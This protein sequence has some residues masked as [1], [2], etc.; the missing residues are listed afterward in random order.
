MG[1][2]L[3]LFSGSAEAGEQLHVLT[4]GGID[5]LANL[6]VETPF[7]QPPQL[8]RGT[9]TE[10]SLTGGGLA[11]YT[12]VVVLPGGHLLL[13]DGAGRGAVRFDDDGEQVDQ[14]FSA[15]EISAPPSVVAA[16][17][18]TTNE[19]DLL[20]MAD[21]TTGHLR[22]YDRVADSYVWNHASIFDG[23][24]P[25]VA[26][27]IAM[28]DKRVAAAG[29]WADESLG[30]VEVLSRETGAEPELVVLSEP[31][32]ERPDA[33]II[34]GLFPV[35]DLM[36]D[37]DGRLLITSRTGVFVVDSGGELLWHFDIGDDADVGGELQSA[38]WLDSGLIAAATRQPGLWNEP[39][40]HHRVHL[41]DPGEEV[42]V[43][44]TSD[45][46][47]AAPLRLE[48]AAGHGATGTRDYSADA[49]DFDDA[50]PEA[51]NVDYGPIID[52]EQIPFDDSSSLSFAV[53]NETAKPVTVRRAEFRV[54]NDACDQLAVPDHLHR[55]WWGYYQTRTIESG[56]GWEMSNQFLDAGD[57]GAGFWC[58]QLMM[59]GRDGQA[60]EVGDPVDFTVLDPAGAD[61]PVT[62]E[63]L[64]EFDPVDAGQPDDAGTSS[65]AN[66]TGNDGE[67]CSCAASSPT[68]PLPALIL[69]MAAILVARSPRQCNG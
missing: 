51:L 41:L 27:A 22:L 58:G 37:L 21:G 17:F 23:A 16:G 63:E 46:F 40:L 7:D 15:G 57:L 52:P 48:P 34:D 25:D 18:V 8:V 64:A 4:A 38:R 3:G 65:P 36:A 55:P 33:R 26:R 10:L 54:A 29:N 6:R 43:V 35:R 19:P 61:G 67:G 53:H 31:H 14:L 49:F 30:A 68:A 5:E 44:A 66:G 60:H 12:D 59:I 50:T 47:D 69:V 9:A 32:S 11:T 62:V 24:R 39:H 13:A 42:P 28:P 56:D 45:S 2:L 20:L 1:V